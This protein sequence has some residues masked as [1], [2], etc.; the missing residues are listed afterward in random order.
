LDQRAEICLG[1]WCLGADT[2]IGRQNEDCRTTGRRCRPS[3]VEC[4]R[5]GPAKR[6]GHRRR[7]G[8]EV[9]DVSL[10]ERFGGA[11]PPKVEEAPAAEAITKDSRSDVHHAVARQ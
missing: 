6:F 4:R 9:A 1:L 8:C 3:D 7:N 10:G 2:E 5:L 11:D